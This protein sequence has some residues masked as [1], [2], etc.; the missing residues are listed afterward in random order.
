MIINYEEII[1]KGNDRHYLSKKPQ[2]VCEIF[3]FE[4]ENMEQMPLGNLYIVTEL[5]SVKDCG[6]LANL[7]ASLIKREYYLNP[8]NGAFKCFQQAVKKANAHLSEMAKEEKTEWLSK[9]HFFCAALTGQNILFTQ[10][11]QMKAYLCRQDHFSCLSRRLNLEGESRKGLPS[12][13]FSAIISGP[14]EQEDKIIIATPE[15]ENII[16]QTDLRQTLIEKQNLPEISIKLKAF[17]QEK[18]Q[19]PLAI[20]L[21]K[22]SKDP[23]EKIEISPKIKM[24][25]EPIDLRELLK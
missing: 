24:T 9:L 23:D 25:T 15:V 21:I 11:G 13:I 7:L 1:R 19:V 17:L 20:L 14:I 5:R 3:S 16:S 18:N 22:P 2:T 12:K 10:A 6:Y 8:S 4:P